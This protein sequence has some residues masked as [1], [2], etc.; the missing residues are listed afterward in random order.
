VKNFAWQPGGGVD[1]AV[2]RVIALR[3]QG[4]LRLIQS[5]GTIKEFRFASGVVF[6]K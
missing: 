2:T 6:R 5:G 4:D 3:L 1:I